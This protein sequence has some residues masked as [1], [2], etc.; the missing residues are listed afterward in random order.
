MGCIERIKWGCV[1]SEYR[2]PPDVRGTF[3]PV[4]DNGDFVKFD[5]AEWVPLLGGDGMRETEP[6]DD[7][8]MLALRIDRGAGVY[9]NTR[10][11]PRWGYLDGLPSHDLNKPEAY[12]YGLSKKQKR[13]AERALRKTI[14]GEG[15]H[16]TFRRLSFA[17]Y[18]TF[19]NVIH[20]MDSMSYKLR[21][22]D[23]YFVQN[24]EKVKDHWRA[25]TPAAV[26]ASG[27]VSPPF[28]QTGG[29]GA[30]PSGVT[31]VEAAATMGADVAMAGAGCFCILSSKG[32]KQFFLFLS[33]LLAL[34]DSVSS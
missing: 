24:P 12:R 9:G 22:N 6:Q 29:D 34:A 5:V 31:T 4:F 20:F 19:D 21:L 16:G 1:N 28:F 13:T 8:I 23:E 2:Q 27:G 3:T 11:L 32:E 14:E 18:T 17:E 7:E 33:G 15:I 25:V 10:R 26:A 30:F